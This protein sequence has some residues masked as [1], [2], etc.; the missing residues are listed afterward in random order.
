MAGWRG[1]PLSKSDGLELERLLRRS[2]GSRLTANSRLELE[3][4]PG[5]ALLLAIEGAQRYPSRAA[6]NALLSALDEAHEYRTLKDHTSLRRS[7]KFS[8]DGHFIVSTAGHSP[9]RQ[10][11]SACAYVGRAH[12]AIAAQT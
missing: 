12:R 6:N 1:L 9:N 3:N 2:E 8:P 10:R 11:E 5:L 7:S 4:D